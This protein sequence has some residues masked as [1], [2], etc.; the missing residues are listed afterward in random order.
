MPVA[1]MIASLSDGALRSLAQG[2]RSGSLSAGSSVYRLA[3]VLAMD[4]DDAARLRDALS[5]SGTDGAGLA[6]ACE[7]A[8]ASRRDS[9][10]TELSKLIEVVLSGP[11]V[12]GVQ[13]RDT[14]VVFSSLI[15][16]AK[17]EILV[18]SFVA[19]YAREL[20]TPLVSFLDGNLSRRATIVLNF[21]RGRDTTIATDLA[22]RLASEFWAQNWPKGARRPALYYDPRGLAT[23]PQERA[24]MHAK[25]VVIDRRTAFVTSAN[26][27][28]R[29]QDQN[30]ELGTLVRHAPMAA[31]I[32][33]Y[34]DAL[35]ANG[36][37]V[38]C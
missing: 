17:E 23:D 37:L 31:R 11:L 19:G 24:S 20:L 5:S 8:L 10:A 35:A 32:A 15:R 21:Q 25:V 36:R 3:D 6:L 28:A 30:I 22:S 27:T 2:L 33:A 38:Q 18:T 7:C 14:S 16:E 9:A 29:A 1:G 34:F 13:M 12:E 4:A 26:L